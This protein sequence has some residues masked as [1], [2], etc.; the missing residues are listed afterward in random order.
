MS[1]A[2]FTYVAQPHRA[3]FR[4]RLAAIAAA[5]AL[6]GVHYRAATVFDL[7][8]S[9]G[10]HPPP[11]TLSQPDGSPLAIDTARGKPTYVFLFA[12]WCGPCQE[13][14]PF[15]RD[16]Y[17]KY[18]DRVNFVGVDVLEDTPAA[19]AS[20][21][22]AALPFPVAYFPID[23]LDAL[24]SPGAQL[25]AGWKYKIPADFLL[26]A[27]GVVRFAWHGLAVDRDGA[28]VDVLPRYLTKLGVE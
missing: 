5:V 21:E 23:R 8:D 9:V 28:A 26:D 7:S 19:V 24:I 17:A 16:D 20:I 22:H 1:G 18:H 2:F 11:L 6:L 15:V 3:M 14:L 13:A 12:S 4:V 25:A 27:N 10:R